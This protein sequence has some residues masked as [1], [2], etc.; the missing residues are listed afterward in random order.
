MF[1]QLGHRAVTWRGFW[2]SGTLALLG[3]V[4]CGCG[5]PYQSAPVNVNKAH[6]T[7]VTA[8]DSWKNG[9]PAES[10][11]EQSPAIVV[12]DFDWIGGMKLLDYE[13]VDE[14][15]PVDANLVA[16]VKLKL[17]DKR[18]TKS[19]KTVTYHVGTAPALTVFRASAQ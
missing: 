1:N 4:Q 18:G 12:Q 6:E 19:D 16:N 11:Q 7:L 14:G 8:L 2:V 3:L 9:D 10:L 15:T 17:Q 13:V 5:G